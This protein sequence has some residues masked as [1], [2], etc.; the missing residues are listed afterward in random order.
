MVRTERQRKLYERAIARLK[1]ARDAEIFGD[2]GS[3]GTGVDLSADPDECSADEL[4]TPTADAWRVIS[5]RRRVGKR[6]YSCD[7]CGRSHAPGDT[8]RVL[9]T[10]YEGELHSTWTCADGCESRGVD[11]VDVDW[12][13]AVGG[14]MSGRTQR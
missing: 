5:D 2:F 4:E 9:V 7:H 12:R 6:A 13:D 10:R 1:A 11:V 14:S 8:M 3:E